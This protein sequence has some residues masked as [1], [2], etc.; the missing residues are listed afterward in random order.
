MILAIYFMD[1]FIGAIVFLSY[2][3]FLTPLLPTASYFL[4]LFLLLI[5][6][7]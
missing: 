6:F 2:F 7:L 4:F 3:L 1:S 5:S